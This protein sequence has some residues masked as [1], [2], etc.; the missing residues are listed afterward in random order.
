MTMTMTNGLAYYSTESIVDVKKLCSTGGSSSRINFFLKVLK[1][2]DFEFCCS[3]SKV[4][5]FHSASPLS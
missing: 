4:Q 2:M 5:H 1:K 3:D